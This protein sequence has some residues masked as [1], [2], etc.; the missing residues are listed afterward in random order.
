MIYLVLTAFFG[1]YLI[2][3]DL[4]IRALG[5]FN[6]LWAL[7]LPGI[8]VFNVVIFPVNFSCRTVC[9]SPRTWMEPAI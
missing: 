6:T 7:V 3:S 5:M 2:P 1:G 8:T 9:P 4:M